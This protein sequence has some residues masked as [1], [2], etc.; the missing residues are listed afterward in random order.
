VVATPV[1][2]ALP[3][4][5]FQKRINKGNLRNLVKRDQAR[6]R[7]L[8]AARKAPQF[9]KRAT[10]SDPVIDEVV[11]YVAA[12]QVGSPPTTFDLIVDTGSSNTWVGSGTR[13]K[14]TS[15]THKLNLRFEVEYGSGAVEGNEVLDRVTIANGLVITNQSIGTA[16]ASEGFSGV[17]GII[18]IGPVDLTAGTLSNNKEIPTVVDNLFSQG[19]ISSHSVAVSFEPTTSEESTN[20]ELTFGGTDSSKFTG[21]ITFT[22]ITQTSPANEFWGIDQSV[23][24][25]GTTLLKS[26]GIVDTGTTLVLL[27]SDAFAAYQAAT[28][29]TIDNTTGLISFTPAQ[30]AALQPLNFVVNGATFSLSANAQLFPRSLNTDIGGTADSIFGVVN[31]LGT[32]SGEG[33]DFVNG[34]SFLERFYSVFDTTNQRIGL[35]TTTLTNATSN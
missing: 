20:G 32:P 21:P 19:T 34:Q 33:L 15:T 25:D 4:A 18:G 29:A 9:G 16:T 35:A 7:A 2:R 5:S 13:F 10:V 8:V 24:Y 1:T 6:V 28:G 22:S 23:T 11:T 17:D 14:S 12:V 31:D 3:A 27:A 30:F 26:S